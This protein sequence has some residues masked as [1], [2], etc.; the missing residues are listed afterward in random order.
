[1]MYTSCRKLVFETKNVSA[2]T[3]SLQMLK[4]QIKHICPHWKKNLSIKCVRKLSY[5]EVV[6][7]IYRCRTKE[8]TTPQLYQ[9]HFQKLK[10]NFM[11]TSN[12]LLKEVFLSMVTL[13]CS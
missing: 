10:N 4:F 13:I 8:K 2:L 5:F 12:F 1:M 6:G 9:I 3:A 7:I 11:P